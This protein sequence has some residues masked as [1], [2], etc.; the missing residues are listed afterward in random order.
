ME[1]RFERRGFE[2]RRSSGDWLGGGGSFMESTVPVAAR[3]HQTTNTLTRSLY[4]K[5]DN[6][7]SRRC[8][9]FVGFRVSNKSGEVI[10]EER[11]ERAPRCLE[12]FRKRQRRSQVGGPH[13]TE[14]SKLRKCSFSLS[15]FTFYY[16]RNCLALRVYFT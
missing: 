1:P 6:T 12:E 9:W 2:I 8:C 7:N 11:V 15:L 14:I 16:S 3:S 10:E 4:F 5:T 13:L